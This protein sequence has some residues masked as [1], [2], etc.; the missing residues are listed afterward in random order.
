MSEGNSKID[1]KVPKM[2]LFGTFLTVLHFSAKMAIFRP[3]RVRV[4]QIMAKM[5]RMAR[6]AKMP[7]VS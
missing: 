6:M 5:A 4:Y 1:R 2:A 3:V 7:N